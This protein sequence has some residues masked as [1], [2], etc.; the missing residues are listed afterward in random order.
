MNRSGQSAARLLTFAGRA[1]QDPL[2][3]VDL[4][5]NIP[6]GGGA[7]AGDNPLTINRAA[8]PLVVTAAVA[9]TGRTA[10]EIA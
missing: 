10:S 3:G 8:T 5:I 6:A 2:A 1:A 4:D 9:W 7:G